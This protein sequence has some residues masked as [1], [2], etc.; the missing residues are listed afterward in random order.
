M[1]ESTTGDPVDGGLPALVSQTTS[2]HAR[3]GAAHCSLSSLPSL[4]GTPR[5]PRTPAHAMHTPRTHMR[6]CRLRRC[7]AA[8]PQ[9]AS[10][11]AAL[12]RRFVC[13]R[14]CARHTRTATRVPTA[15]ATPSRRASPFAPLQARR[16]LLRSEPRRAA[17]EPPIARA[18]LPDRLR[19]SHAG[20]RPNAT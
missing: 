18:R 15:A 3:C 19:L 6:A 12:P 20:T 10:R 5:T 1:S 14:G 16:S 2:R 9:L 7:C 17:L 13:H 11:D 8:T 4:N